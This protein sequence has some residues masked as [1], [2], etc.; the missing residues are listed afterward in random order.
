MILFPDKISL[1]GVFSPGKQRPRFR[2]FTITVFLKGKKIK[3]LSDYL[4]YC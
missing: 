4:K 3:K 1:R 2:H